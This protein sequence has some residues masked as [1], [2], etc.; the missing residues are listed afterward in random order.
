MFG[1]LFLEIKLGWKQLWCVHNYEK[2][3]HREIGTK[4]YYSSD[5]TKCGKFKVR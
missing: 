3:T 4:T 5:C 1:D 2:W